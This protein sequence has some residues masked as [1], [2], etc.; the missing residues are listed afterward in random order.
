MKANLLRHRLV[1]ILALVLAGS[2]KAQTTEWPLSADQ[3]ATARTAAVVSGF[4]PIQN[5][6]KSWQVS[7]S[8]D[9]LLQYPGEDSGLLWALELRDWLVALGVPQS[10]IQLS[11]GS[12]AA[13]ILELKLVQTE[14]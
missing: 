6:M 8:H 13:D 7:A 3:W 2:V 10:R 1:F 9:L 5:M 11:A 12:R 14:R 4:G